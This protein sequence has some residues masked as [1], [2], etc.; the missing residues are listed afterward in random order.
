M[1]HAR[2]DKPG[3]DIHL[4]NQPGYGTAIDY[5]VKARDR[6]D[7]A[8][9][10]LPV[11][12]WNIVNRLHKYASPATIPINR[13]V[14]TFRMAPE[15]NTY[16]WDKAWVPSRA[17]SQLI[18]PREPCTP[19]KADKSVLHHRDGGLCGVHSGGCGEHVDGASNDISRD[20]MV[21]RSYFNSKEGKKFRNEWFAEW[22]SQIMH[23]GCNA[24]RGAYEVP[25]RYK[26]QCHFSYIDVDQGNTSV[27]YAYPG[28]EWERYTV[29]DGVIGPHDAVWRAIPNPQPKRGGGTRHLAPAG[30]AGK[31]SDQVGLVLPLFTEY[32]AHKRNIDEMARIDPKWFNTMHD[33]INHAFAHRDFKVG[34]DGHFRFSVRIG[35]GIEAPRL[36]FAMPA[37]DADYFRRTGHYVSAVRDGIELTLSDHKAVEPTSRSI[38]NAE[39]RIWEQVIPEDWG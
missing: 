10:Q 1:Q 22:N 30:W 4:A 20:E 25:P 32:E 39:S 24:K 28:N 11:H 36:T 6:I 21:P 23:Q 9:S 3:H 15:N 29:C 31:N 14:M 5:L 33:I 34:L 19:G 35:V 7:L 16:E 27:L 12:S 2:D 17:S 8:P 13:D 26:C 37:S 38:L 18:T